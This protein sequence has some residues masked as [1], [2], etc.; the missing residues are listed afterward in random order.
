MKLLISILRGAIVFSLVT[1]LY[2]MPKIINAKKMSV[3][4]PEKPS[5]LPRT[6]LLIGG[7]LFLGYCLLTILPWI[8]AAYGVS[9]DESWGSAFHIAFRDKIQFGDNF[10]YTYGP[11]GFLRTAHYF[12][13]ETFG[14]SVGF[15]V[16]IAIATWVGLFRLARYCLSRRD[17]SVLF[18]FGILLFFPNYLISS[19][20]FQFLLVSLP[21]LIYFYVSQRV[22]PALV[23]TLANLALSSLT[24][25][26]YL[27]LAVA[28]VILITIDEVG[29]L[30]RIPRIAP[31][32]LA[33]MWI[34]WVFAAQ[35]LADFP[36]YVINGL[37]IVKGFSATMGTVGA[38]DEVLLYLASAGIFMA[39]ALW[40]EWQQRRWWGMLPVL[41]LAASLFIT[42][43]GAFARHD[44]HALQTI[45]NAV[46][47][48]LAYTAMLWSKIPKTRFSL[49]KIK[50]PAIACL[51]VVATI[52]VVMGGII[53]QR[54]LNFSYTTFAWRI[55]EHNLQRVDLIR[56]MSTGQVNL[57]AMSEQ[58]KATI[59]AANP[60]PPVSGGVDLYPNKTA[61]IFANNFAYQPRPVIQS[62]SAYTAKLAR[63]N[64]DHLKTPD[65]APNI[66]FDLEPIDGRLA[67]FEDG[68]SWLEILT[69]Y[70]VTN[71]EGRYLLM[72]RSPQPRE[73]QLQ[74]ITDEVEVPLNQWFDLDGKPNPIWSKIDLHPNLLGKLISAA[75]RL[76]PIHLEIE[77]ADGAKV[78]Y[79][80]VGD[81][82]SEGFLLSP[83]LSDRWEFLDFATPN[84]QEELAHRQVKRFR[85]VSNGLN[86]LLYPANYH[87]S[88]S[89]PQFSR[90][91]FS[92]VAG[93]QQWQDSLKP[94][95]LDGAL[96]KITIDDTE[97]EGLMAHAPVKALVELP[98]DRQ[99][100]SFSFGILE[101]GVQEAIEQ[102]GGDGVEFKIIALLANGKEQELFARK[103]QPMKNK[104]DRGIQSSNIDLTKIDTNRLILETIPGENNLWDWSYWSALE[105]N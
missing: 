39:I 3:I 96:T 47:I 41:G 49:G 20:Y 37:E 102:N 7:L 98:K 86:S 89:Q 40:L 72:Q 26:T 50:L 48:L 84:W 1:I 78:M 61:N 95:P 51:V 19:D 64:R 68:L 55:T 59:R 15:S 22:T 100:F 12:F 29:R 91:D 90:Q 4:N 32:Y 63:M 30:K 79:R 28:F 71:V 70:D 52:N 43:K 69:L 73:Y 45:F 38:M 83:V 6:T 9:L 35:K 76:P 13:P 27:M 104:N 74:P 42:F 94:R 75:L 67:A 88:L 87:F 81:V 11:Y 25:H 65:A 10:I 80:I 101:A 17:G 62:F 60:L 2:L 97:Q 16:V 77:T 53:L 31:I 21:L 24:K 14:Y 33:F 99:N 44:A 82:I 58:G 34:L 56:R 66:F 105:A 92:Q 103:L 54:Y 36:A 85:I 46:P 8:P 93:W 23:V 5:I 18:L 57:T